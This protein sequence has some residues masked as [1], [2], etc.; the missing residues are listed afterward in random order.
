MDRFANMLKHLLL[1]AEDAEQVADLGILARAALHQR[2]DEALASVLSHR[3]AELQAQSEMPSC[4]K[5]ANCMGLKQN[6]PIRVRT[7][8]TGLPLKVVSPIPDCSQC[9]V[10]AT[11]LRKAL[12]LDAD[13]RTERL[14]L[15]AT[16][17]A[18]VELYEAASKGL[19][20][21]IG[22]I[23][24]SANGIQAICQQAGALPDQPMASGTSCP[25]AATG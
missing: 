11:L 9:L 16:T 8:Q 23:T 3:A 13:G 19:M 18:T 5:C 12:H 4:P 10:G 7:A 20:A 6:R 2:G 22:G 21:E 24:A 17:A 14:R 25:Y 1:C 15:L